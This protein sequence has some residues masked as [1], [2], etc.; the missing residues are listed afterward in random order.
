MRLLAGIIFGAGLVIGGAYLHDSNLSGPFQAQQRL[1]NWD[2][3]DRLVG[4]AYDD[5]RAKIKEW[6]GY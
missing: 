1:V 2:V 3:A 6:T 4:D 5:S